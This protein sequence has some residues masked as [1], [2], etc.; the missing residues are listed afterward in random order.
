M[1]A[2]LKRMSHG[3]PLSKFLPVCTERGLAP[4]GEGAM[5]ELPP[6]RIL[7]TRLCSRLSRIFHVSPPH[8]GRA[9]ANVSAVAA[10]QAICSRALLRAIFQK[11]LLDSTAE[12]PQALRRT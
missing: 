10:V 3:S 2:V 5:T 6:E 7:E 4:T 11:T 1:E 8:A 12:E 9:V